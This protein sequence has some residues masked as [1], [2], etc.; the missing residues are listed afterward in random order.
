M[1]LVPQ[2]IH[3]TVRYNYSSV[4]F[5]SGSCVVRW[6]DA[7][8]WQFDCVATLSTATWSLHQ[9]NE[10][11]CGK[12]SLGIQWNTC[13]HQSNSKLQRSKKCRSVACF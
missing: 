11:N 1:L 3:T 9:L 7:S 4:I 12:R 5:W 6:M 13:V 2:C 8:E 10:R